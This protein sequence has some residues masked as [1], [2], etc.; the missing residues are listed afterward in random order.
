MI[1]FLYSVPSELLTHLDASIQ[2]PALNGKG[3]GAGPGSDLLAELVDAGNLAAGDP[4]L[5]ILEPVGLLGK[6]SLDVLADLDALINVLGNTLKVLLAE[7]TAAHGR[8]TNTDTAR[9]KSALVSRNGVLVASNVDLL[10]DSLNTSTIQ[11]V[12]AEID[13]NHVAVSA[14]R[15]HLVT[16]SLEGVLKSLGVGNDLLLVSLELG[17]GGLLEGNSQGSD[18]VVVRSTLVARE[19]GEVD[20]VLKVIEGLLASLGIN[21]ADTL[22][23]EDHGTSG[24]TERLVGGGCDDISVLERSRDDLSSDETRDVSH[25]NNKVGANRVSNLAHALVVNQTAVGRGTG[26][27]D[28][29]AVENGVLGEHVVIDDASLKVNSVRHGLKVGRDSGD[30]VGNNE[31]IY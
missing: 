31:S 5:E 17:S 14:V 4:G 23:E 2:T 27:E 8:G 25:V 30:P 3:E 10:K 24:A 29:G 7:A 13:K 12:L 19:D 16:K 15:N 26:D 1:L 20:G 28:L 21:R 9:G 11:A 6:R 22:A 18:G